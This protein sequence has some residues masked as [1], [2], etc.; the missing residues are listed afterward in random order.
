MRKL[1]ILPVTISLV[2]ALTACSVATG[3]EGDTTTAGSAASGT[4]LFDSSTVHDISIEFDDADYD[5]IIAAY[6]ADGS[7][8]WLSAT[9]TIDGTSFKN[10]GLRL[11]GNSSLRGITGDGQSPSG[12]ESG[13]VDDPS[14]LPW[15]IRFDEYVEGQT[16]QG[17]S[18][19]V[20]R[21]NNTETSLNE[22]VALELIG[23]AGLATEEAT[24][25]R[26]TINGGTAQL[27]LVIES[28]DDELWSDAVFGEDGITYEAETE[29][30][31]SYRGDDAAAYDNVFTVQAGED[32][33]QPV[34]DLLAFVDSASDADFE[35]HLAD[36]M[37][38]DALAT[39]L[40]LEPLIANDDDI[41]GPGNNSYLRWDAGTGLITVVAWD[42][43]LA[44]GGFGHGIGGQNGG[45]G[46]G[47]GGGM[48]GAGQGGPQG[49]AGGQGQGAGG[50]PR[51]KTNPLT[52][53]FLANDTFAAMVADATTSLQASLYDSGEAQAIL[54]EWVDVLESEAGDLVDT[55]TVE[56]D[57]AR[58]S[59]YF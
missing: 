36:Y 16:Y 9:V 14:T 32:D 57:A 26:L 37:D 51:N 7:K 6:R 12:D 8:E 15:L 5:A 24:P 18:E 43:N 48:P 56:S 58:I 50:G 46:Q 47:Q 31:Y 52:E 38:V 59:A 19:L 11:K 34:I 42:H 55:A 2:A 27:R 25:T 54:D 29:G 41:D 35:T 33:L 4:D 53:R 40:A 20:V 10:V 17:R 22:A 30:D 44:F 13:D 23:E 21:G 45:A 1:L 28:P 39:Y 3:L 49:Q